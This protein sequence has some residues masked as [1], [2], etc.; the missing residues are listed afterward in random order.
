MYAT[1]V[2]RSD[3]TIKD[4]I[5][6]VNLSSYKYKADQLSHLSIKAKD[7][8]NDYCYN[9]YYLIAVKG[10]PGVNEEVSIVTEGTPVII[11]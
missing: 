4:Y 3:K 1:P 2:T 5:D 6:S 7:S 11:K 10:T 9:C 8:G